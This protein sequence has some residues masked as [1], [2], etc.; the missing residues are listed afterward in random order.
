MIYLIASLQ[1]PLIQ[2]YL[3]D[4]LKT[5]LDVI[6]DFSVVTINAS[7]VLSE[8][9]AYEAT[10][11]PIGTSTK[12]LLIENAYYLLKTKKRIK[13]DKEQNFKPLLEVIKQKDKDIDLIFILDDLEIDQKHEVYQAIKK[14]GEIKLIQTLSENELFNYGYNYFKKLDVKIANNALKELLNRVEGDLITFHNEANKLALY[15]NELQLNDIHQFIKKPLES[16]VFSLTNALFKGDVV[17][18]LDIFRDLRVYNVEPVTL[19]SLISNQFRLMYQVSYLQRQGLN[20]FQIAQTLKIHEYRAKMLLRDS[21]RHSLFDIL[22]YLEKLYELD[23]NIKSGQI[24]RFY[25]FELFL[26][27]F[28]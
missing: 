5:R 6:D 4:Y 17:T 27:R 3:N 18:A 2:N 20:H 23:L 22:S 11:L 24:D 8:D 19:I 14:Y 7:E 1:K 21:R 9:I 25:G 28:N 13:I 10:Y 15:K 16:N 26:L 12:V